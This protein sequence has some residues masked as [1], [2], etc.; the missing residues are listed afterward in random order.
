MKGFGVHARWEIRLSL[1]WHSSPRGSLS[2][3]QIVWV[4]A[5]RLGL[6]CFIQ[7][8]VCQRIL[9]GIPVASCTTVTRLGKGSPTTPAP[10]TKACSLLVQALGAA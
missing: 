3:S 1:P 10:R 2:R 7:P 9:G 4:G 6:S 8:I 5:S